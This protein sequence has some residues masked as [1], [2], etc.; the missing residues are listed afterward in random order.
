LAINRGESKKILK[1]SIDIP[2]SVRDTFVSRCV[3]QYQPHRADEMLQQ[4]VVRSAN[5]AY[6][7]LVQPMFARSFRFATWN[8][9]W[10]VIFL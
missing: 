7:R 4:L 1:V 8:P 6:D 9:S 2:S 3:A 5:D 10:L